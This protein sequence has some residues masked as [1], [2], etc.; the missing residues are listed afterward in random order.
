MSDSGTYCVPPEGPH[1]SYLEYIA[2]FPILPLPEAFGLHSNADITKDLGQTALLTETLIK[3]GGERGGGG[4]KE[5]LVAN[6]T[7]DILEKLPANFDIEAVQR[8]FPVLY[9]E[10]M[11]TVLAQEMLRYN[12]LLSIIRSS[13]QQLQRAIAG[14]SVMSA[15]LEKVFNAF[16]IGQVPAAWMGKSFPSLKPLASYVKDLLARL[17]LFEGVVPRRPAEPSSGSAASS[18]PRRSPP[19][20]SKTSRAVTSTPSTRW[21]TRWRCSTW[22]LQST[23][24]RRRRASTY[25]ACS[26]RMAG[27]RKGADESR[28]KVLFEF[29][30]CIWLK[31]TLLKDMNEYKHY[32]C[33]VYR[34]AERRGVLAT[35]DT[36]Q[37]FDDDED[38]DGIGEDH[39]TIMRVCMLCCSLS[40]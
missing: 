37:L 40:D 16:A 22:I 23:Q 33:P 34:T 14:L 27:P 3:T 32:P 31:P 2:G 7:K 10:S 38:T 19:P 36:H 11:N 4:G 18:S 5:Q 1:E 21:G 25:T 9:E 28:P 35:T 24:S 29:A 8:K 6:I 20:R 13:L 39:W 30:P 15:E 17:A 26:S 12:R